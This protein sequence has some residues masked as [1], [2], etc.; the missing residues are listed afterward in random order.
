MAVLWIGSGRVEFTSTGAVAAGAKAYFY[1][2]GTTTPRG[3]YSDNAL[4]TLH[5]QPVVADGSGRF[6]AIYL[7]TGLAK[8]R[9]VTSAGV[10]L[11][12]H[13][14]IDGTAPT[15]S[16]PDA[17]TTDPELLLSTGDIIFRLQTGTRSGYVR[18]NAR[19]I[20]SASSGATERANA[21]TQDLFEYLWNNL[22]DSVCPV[23]GGRGANAAADFAANKTI[24]TPDLR[25]R[26]L[27]GLDD[28]G[29][30]AAGRLTAATITAPT[31]PGSA[32][33]V[34]TVTL[35]VAQMPAH[36]HGGVTGA[37]SAHSHTY[38]IPQFGT[39]QSGTGTSAATGST[40]ASTSTESAHTHT[41]SSQGGGAAHS[42]LP[43]GM[44]ATAYI[45]L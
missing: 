31:T 24:G 28:M 45:K 5:A 44:V 23:S 19:T 27:F 6:P 37:G 42:N 22:S 3:V 38:T 21:D 43:P 11:Y 26:S 25:G 2:A 13:D 33:G 34:E 15:A 30:S 18:A 9:V 35:S 41:I 40:S 12:E 39:V 29:N 4:S 10:L 8:A 36:D 32:G 1:D 14:N 17:G 16:D 20:G 7:P